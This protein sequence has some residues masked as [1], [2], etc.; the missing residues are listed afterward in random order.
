MVVDRRRHRE[1]WIAQASQDAPAGEIGRELDDRHA[2]ELV[3][4]DVQDL[5]RQED[6]VAVRHALS[7]EVNLASRTGARIDPEELPG[8]GLNRDAASCRSGS[9]R[10]R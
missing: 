10:F 9:H 6:A 7:T 2:V 3:L 8:V 1:V 5:S 4:N